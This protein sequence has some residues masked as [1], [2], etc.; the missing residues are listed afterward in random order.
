MYTFKFIAIVNTNKMS[1][2]LKMYALC[3]CFG[4]MKSG[5][6]TP[7]LK[8]IKKH[9]VSM[10]FLALCTY[11]YSIGSCFELAFV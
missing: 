6:I 11:N 9:N 4:F 5:F 8:Q 3:C 1:Y 7:W 2:L 10:F